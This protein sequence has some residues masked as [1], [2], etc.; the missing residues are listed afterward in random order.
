ML[1][2]AVINHYRHQNVFSKHVVQAVNNFITSAVIN[3]AHNF[4][5][6]LQKAP[7]KEM[8]PS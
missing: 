8:I 4:A 3:I 6:T 2:A 7:R 1:T 5:M